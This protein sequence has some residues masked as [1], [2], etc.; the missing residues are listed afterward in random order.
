VLFPQLYDKC[1]GITRKD[2]ARLA[3]FQNFSVVL[4]IVCFMTFCVLFVCKCV[5]YNCHRAATH[6]QL[7][8]I[9]NIKISITL[10]RIGIRGFVL[11]LKQPEHELEGQFHLDLILRLHGVLPTP[12]HIFFFF[13]NRHYNT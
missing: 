5:L 10:Y 6:L 1:Q 12:I 2:G 3:L 8:N 11:V 9:S 13:F 4:C 7:K